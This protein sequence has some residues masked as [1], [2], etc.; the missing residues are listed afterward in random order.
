MIEEK[1]ISVLQRIKQ[2]DGSY[3]IYLPIN[4]PINIANR[5]ETIVLFFMLS[6]IYIVLAYYK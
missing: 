2:E 1:A 5:I 4:T 6:P 3:V